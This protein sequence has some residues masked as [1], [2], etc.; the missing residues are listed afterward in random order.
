[1]NFECDS[2]EKDNCGVK[3]FKMLVGGEKMTLG[4]EWRY[5]VWSNEQ[6][7]ND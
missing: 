7:V 2:A 6:F 5:F 4:Y 3:E 1:M